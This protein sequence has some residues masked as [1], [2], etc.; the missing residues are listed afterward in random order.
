[1]VQCTPIHKVDINM[2]FT[3]WLTEE[4]D[5]IRIAARLRGNGTVDAM[6]D[7]DFHDAYDMLA[8]VC[9]DK[10]QYWL[11]TTSWEV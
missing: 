8:L 7:G 9:K 3:E 2:Q 10:D 1:M 6:C 11:I 5:Q 4:D